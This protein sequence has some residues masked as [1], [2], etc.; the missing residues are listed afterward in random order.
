[1][2]VNAVVGL[3]ILATSIADKHI[4]TVLPTH[5]LIKCWQRIKS[6]VPDIT[7]VKPLPLVLCALVL[8]QL[9]AG[10]K[11]QITALAGKGVL[12]PY[13]APVQ[14]FQELPWEPVLGTSS[15][16]CQQKRVALHVIFEGE[17]CIEGDVAGYT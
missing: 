5:V 16:R 8:H 14:H 17:P 11:L 2:L 10:V 13:A 4:A 3:F 6:P 9:L 1:M 7:R 15:S 12:V